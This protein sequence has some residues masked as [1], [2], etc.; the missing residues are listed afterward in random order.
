MHTLLIAS[1]TETI[2]LD[3]FQCCC[4]ILGF[5]GLRLQEIVLGKQLPFF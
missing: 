4:Y 2:R 3:V 1:C 5:L